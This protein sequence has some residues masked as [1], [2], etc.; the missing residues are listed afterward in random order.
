MSQAWAN[1]PPLGSA[2]V[3]L[4][5]SIPNA[6]EALR[7]VHSG[8]SAPSSTVAYMLWADTSAALLKQRNAANDGWIVLG[9]LGQRH[10]WLS[11]MCQIGAVGGTLSIDLLV[12]PCDMTIQG[13]YIVS[14]TTTWGS[15]IDDNYSVQLANV[16]QGNNLLATPQNTESEN[17]ES[18]IQADT[19]WPV[20]PDQNTLV[21]AGDLLRLT[22]TKNGVGPVDS[23][24]S[25]ARVSAQIQGHTR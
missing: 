8:S 11:Q 15:T 6:L 5:T 22:I 24:L 13:L 4:K 16:T 10:D 3:A 20:T 7:T 19:P 1:I 12:A 25:A 23:D 18:E 9:S 14:D 21:F 17:P 2:S